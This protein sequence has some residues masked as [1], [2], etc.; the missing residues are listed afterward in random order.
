VIA[1]L[2]RLQAD[3]FGDR[4]FTAAL[5]ESQQRVESMAMIH[6][7]LYQSADLHCVDI[8]LHAGLVLTN[9]LHAY[10]VSPSR[11]QGHIGLGSGSLL[12][13]VDQAI[14]AGLILNELISN[15]LKHGFPE[16]RSG[17]I[18]VEAGWR[19]SSVLL[20]VRDNGVGLHEDFR[21]DR[22]KSLGLHI[23]QILTSQLKGKVEVESANGTIFRVLF[24]APRIK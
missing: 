8:G 5:H 9:L 11:I 19:D 14:P 15:A 6:E 16:G 18:A 1:S 23:V 20:E 12:L 4:A 2:L 24:P 21:L 22:T 17:S 3:A 7:Q 10:G 13:G